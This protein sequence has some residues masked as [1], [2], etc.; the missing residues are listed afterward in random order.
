M[1]VVSHLFGTPE[2]VPRRLA[3]CRQSIGRPNEDSQRSDLC[4][5][6]L[7]QFSIPPPPYA[8]IS[9]QRYRDNQ[10]NGLSSGRALSGRLKELIGSL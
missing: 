4:K 1:E 2:Q 5:Q 6:F 9:W 7:H 8:Y 3:F 10:A